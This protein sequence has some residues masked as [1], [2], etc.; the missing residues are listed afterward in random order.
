MSV[1][2]RAPQPAQYP[3]DAEVESSSRTGR[4]PALTQNGSPH[5][6]A[7]SSTSRPQ[8]VHNWCRAPSAALMSSSAASSSSCSAIPDVASSSNSQACRL[9]MPARY[10]M[11]LSPDDDGSSAP[12]RCTAPAAT[13]A[14]QLE[15]DLLALLAL[16]APT[17]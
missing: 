2:P 8:P 16:L 12:C 1:G 9:S 6:A 11:C 3:S 4:R 10:G 13:T 14:A 7:V 15:H 17:E 5:A